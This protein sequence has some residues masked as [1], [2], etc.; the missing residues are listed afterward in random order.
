MSS[1]EIKEGCERDPTNPLT[2]GQQ[3][4]LG[5]EA[6]K[7]WDKVIKRKGPKHPNPKNAQPQGAYYTPSAATEALLSVEKFPSNIYEPA[8]GKG[9]I[10]KVLIDNG[11]NVMSSD[12]NDWGYG[13]IGYDFLT[14]SLVTETIQPQNCGM[15]T[16]PPFKFADEFVI[17]AIELGFKKFAIFNSL[18]WLRGERRY[19]RLWDI[20]PPTTVYVLSKRVSCWRMDDPNPRAT[21][22]SVDYGWYV[23][24]METANDV[25]P[26]SP[27]LKWIK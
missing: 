7:E 19:D 24:D 21:G 5:D 11:Y 3:I 14:K 20:H 9:H 27:L 4:M 23:W 18:G 15:I 25:Y 6:A 13:H 2:N 22:G 10:S 16:N 12:L 1:F 17:R 26:R 8:C